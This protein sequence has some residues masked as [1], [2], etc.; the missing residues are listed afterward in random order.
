MDSDGNNIIRLTDD[1]AMDSNPQ[2]SPTGGQIAFVS[3]RDGNA[4]LYVMNSNGR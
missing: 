1:S 3:Y 4:E 2:W